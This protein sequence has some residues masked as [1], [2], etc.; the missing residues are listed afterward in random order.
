VHVA[1]RFHYYGAWLPNT[2][3]AKGVSNWSWGIY[4]TAIFLVSSGF[5]PLV[6]LTAGPILMRKKWVAYASV[7]SSLTLLHNL[8]VGGDFIFTGRFLFP[9]LPLI[10]LLV[11]ELFRLAS[12]AIADPACRF[13]RKSCLRVSQA[14]I[15]I[16]IILGAFIELRLLRFGVRFSRDL[17]EHNMHVSKC[18]LENTGP[19]DTIALIAAGVVPYYCDRT[20][21]DMLGLTDQHI[22]RYGIIDKSCT[23]AHQRADSDYVL[24]REPKIILLAQPDPYLREMTFPLSLNIAANN[25]MHNNPRLLEEYEE[26]LLDCDVY[27]TLVFVRR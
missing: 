26:V 7:I 3:Y 20:I 13:G 22:A 11:Q 25:Q 23:I 19:A 24:D 21:I 9:L 1:W 12:T 14:A 8:R 17:N 16:F 18:I 15:I 4:Y 6:A 10:Y 2:Y 5:L 27:P